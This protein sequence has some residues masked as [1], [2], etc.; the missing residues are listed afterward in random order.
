M[1]KKLLIMFVVVP[2]ILILCAICFVVFKSYKHKRISESRRRTFNTFTQLV[3]AQHKYFTEH[4]SYASS[5]DQLSVNAVGVKGSGPCR[6]NSTFCVG[7]V[8][9]PKPETMQ[10]IYVKD[11][12]DYD[13]CLS[14]DTNGYNLISDAVDGWFYLSN[15]NKSDEIMC[16][17]AYDFCEDAGGIEADYGLYFIP[18]K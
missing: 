18:L 1:K 15:S 16:L 2:L 7:S 17:R 9:N 5:F 3:A 10:C 6:A 4:G 8:G 11:Y 14:S 13:F 12:W